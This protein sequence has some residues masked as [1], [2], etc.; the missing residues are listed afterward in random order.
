M[1][2]E[3]RSRSW[4]RVDAVRNNDHVPAFVL[5]IGV[6][7][8]DQLHDARGRREVDN[9]NVVFREDGAHTPLGRL[10]RH[11]PGRRGGL[12]CGDAAQPGRLRC[13]GSAARPV[14]GAGIPTNDREPVAV[15]RGSRGGCLR[16]VLRPAGEHDLYSPALI[17]QPGWPRP[18]AKPFPD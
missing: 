9:Q 15:V 10:R 12:R 7:F 13:I 11:V 2:A 17:H 5:R 4:H 14:R 16:C 6:E 8:L 18:W 3:A 1:A